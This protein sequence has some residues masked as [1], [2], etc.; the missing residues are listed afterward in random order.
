MQEGEQRSLFT[1]W[2]EQGRASGHLRAQAFKQ[3]G[4]IS[5]GGDEMGQCSGMTNREIALVVLAQKAHIAIDAGSEHSRAAAYRF[6]H[7]MGAPLPVSY[8]PLT[9]P[10]NNKG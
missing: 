2:I 3:T 9:P 10:T 4:N 5:H 7:H 6:D 8:P 1:S